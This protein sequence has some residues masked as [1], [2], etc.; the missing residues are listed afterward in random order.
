MRN[1]LLM[2]GGQWVDVAIHESTPA[3]G[4][5]GALR[6]RNYWGLE[7]PRAARFEVFDLLKRHIDNTK[8]ASLH[9]FRP[10]LK[11][12]FRSA[13]VWAAIAAC[14]LRWWVCP[15]P[16]TDTERSSTTAGYQ[17]GVS[18]HDHGLAA[19]HP[20]SDQC[21]QLLSD[22]NSMA[23]PAALIPPAGDLAPVVLIA[24]VAMGLLAAWGADPLIKF[25]PHSNGPPRTRY[26]RF[27]TFWSH[28]PPAQHA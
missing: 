19:E 14:V 9:P 24:I 2:S 12:G 6:G 27:A 28:A 8:V 4:A 15:V 3:L 21:C 7:T 16:D 11:T 23:V 18:V 20:D 5:V 17:Q 1:D 25:T 26:R 22:S 13:V 10:V